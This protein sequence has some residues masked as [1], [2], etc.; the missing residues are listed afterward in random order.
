M[1]AVL[2]EGRARTSDLSG[3]SATTEVTNRVIEKLARPYQ[4]P[5]TSR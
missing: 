5:G 3:C 2:K 1:H 4:T